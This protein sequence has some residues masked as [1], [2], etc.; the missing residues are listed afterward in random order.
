M[1]HPGARFGVVTGEEDEREERT[2]A[3]G[4]IKRMKVGDDDPLAARGSTALA[5]RMKDEWHCYHVSSISPR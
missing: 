4:G 2:T 1:G 3:E 5:A